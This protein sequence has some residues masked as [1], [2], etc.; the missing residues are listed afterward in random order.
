MGWMMVG[1]LGGT[2][3]WKIE[4]KFGGELVSLHFGKAT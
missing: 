4:G 3:E 2:M 1:Q